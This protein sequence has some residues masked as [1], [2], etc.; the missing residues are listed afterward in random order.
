MIIM[1]MLKILRDSREAVDLCEDPPGGPQ[2]KIEI[3]KHY[4]NYRIYKIYKFCSAAF[5]GSAA[6]GAGRWDRVVAKATCQS[7]NGTK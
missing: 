7:G 1:V 2:R 6:G 5:R 4:I 3:Y